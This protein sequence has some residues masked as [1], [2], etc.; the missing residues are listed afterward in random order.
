MKLLQEEIKSAYD[1]ST[2]KYSRHYSTVQCS[3]VHSTVH[4]A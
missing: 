2:K 4:G 3:A 1:D